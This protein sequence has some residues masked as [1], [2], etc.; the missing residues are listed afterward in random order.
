M[1]SF[2]DR[3]FPESLENSI[4]PKRNMLEKWGIYLG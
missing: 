1:S 3:K 4:I 2:G